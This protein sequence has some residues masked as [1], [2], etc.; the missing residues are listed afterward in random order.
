MRFLVVVSTTAVQSVRGWLWGLR[1]W[2]TANS[3][4][5]PL[6]FDPRGIVIGHPAADVAALAIGIGGLDHYRKMLEIGEAVDPKMYDRQSLEGHAGTLLVLYAGY[7]AEGLHRLR[8]AS[9]AADI[10]EYQATVARATA[11]TEQAVI[12]L[13]N[14]SNMARATGPALDL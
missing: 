4:R 14:F 11:W 10:A 6:L 7:Q 13:G 2:R 9:D 5:S 12:S 8:G 1:S 3:S